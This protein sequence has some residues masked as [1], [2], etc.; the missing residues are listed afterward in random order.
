LRQSAIGEM[1][2]PYAVG[3]KVAK[4]LLEAGAAAILDEVRSQND[5]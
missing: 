2:V 3:G 1:T 5:L 4:M